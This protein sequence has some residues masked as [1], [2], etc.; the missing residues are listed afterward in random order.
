[1]VNEFFLLNCQMLKIFVCV[2]HM[3]LF[4]KSNINE[5]VFSFAGLI[6][7]SWDKFIGH[8]KIYIK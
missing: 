5:F 3:A 1:M 7:N 6:T 8:L 2:M 4:E